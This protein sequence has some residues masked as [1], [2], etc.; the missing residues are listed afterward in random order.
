MAKIVYNYD[1]LITYCN[2]NN[3]N[4]LEDYSDQIINGKFIV[5]GICSG[6]KCNNDFEKAFSLMI[7]NSLCKSC[8]KKECI[9]KFEETTLGKF[10]TLNPS[11]SIVCKNKRAISMEKQF[12][13][14]GIKMVRYNYESLIKYCNEKNITLLKDYSKE[15]INKNFIIESKCYTCIDGICKKSICVFYKNPYCPKCTATKR[16]ETMKKNNI[17]KYGVEHVLQYKDFTPFDI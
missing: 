5:K 7:K 12:L 14:K 17:E 6:E 11:Q 16:L 2:D 8:T 4:L 13:E 1:F 9:R 10:G 15:N 3:I